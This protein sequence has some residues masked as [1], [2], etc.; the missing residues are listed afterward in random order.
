MKLQTAFLHSKLARRIFWL[1]VLCALVPITVLALVSLRNVSSQLEEESHSQLHQDAREEAMIVYER[2]SFLEADLKLVARSIRPQAIRSRVPPFAGTTALSTDLGNRIKG[3]EL[4]LPDRTRRP[5][6][7]EIHSRFDFSEKELGFLGL[8]KNVLSTFPCN[9]TTPCVYLSRELEPSYPEKGILVAEIDTSYLWD[10]ENLPAE[11]D[12]CILDDME[13]AMFCSGPSPSLFPGQ[14]THSFSGEFEWQQNQ[15]RFVADYWN[16]PLEGSF[17]VPHWTIVASRAKQNVLAPLAHFKTN[18]FFVYLLAIWVVL[19]L[20]LI[21]IRRNLVPLTQLK[22]GTGQ[23]SLGNFKTRVA[24][25]SGDEFEDLASS[26]NFMADRIEKQLNSLKVFNEIDRAILS[27]WDIEKIVETILSRLGELLPLDQVGVA[28]FDAHASTQAVL[29]TYGSSVQSR[30]AEELIEVEAEEGRKLLR[31][32]RLSIQ[33][34]KGDLP[35]Y[36]KPLQA[37]GMQHF[38]VIPVPVED[39]LGALLILAHA[40]SSPWSD[41]DKERA[42]KI[43]DQFAVALANSRLVTQLHQLQWGTLT[44]LARAIDAKSPWTLGHSERVTKH[45]VRIAQ[46]MRLGPR[47]LDTIRR[48]CLLHDVGKIGTPVSILD[49]AGKL[50]EEELKIMQEH[51]TIG[52]R[53][54]EPVP[55][56]SEAMPIVLQHHEWVNGGGYPQGLRGDQITLHARIVAVA[57]CFDALVSDR[58]YRKGLS[59]ERAM[60]IIQ[61]GSNKQFDPL[62]V[63][64][65]QAIVKQDDGDSKRGERVVPAIEVRS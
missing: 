16:L 45:A 44:A 54:L 7:G 37:R 38:L 8:A 33:A 41:E 53:I 32:H 20:S 43:G 19:L 58:P 34:S 11:S 35:E 48:G 23:L 10:S 63:E 18:F 47:D 27:A 12:T 51:V 25:K 46:A 2:L 15:S 61:E 40:T 29:Y 52:G 6:F 5:L 50:T 9:G 30:R 56:L 13:R 17:F 3:L 4:V 59:A 24:V 22:E 31:H 42:R 64:V 60:K 1:F 65:F 55:D 57:D 28:L 14:M 21:Q 26:F 36:L 62:V 39:Q 49:K